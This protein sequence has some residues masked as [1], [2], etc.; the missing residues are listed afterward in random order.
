M[1]V[2]NSFDDSKI[3]SESA[4]GNSTNWSNY[5]KLCFEWHPNRQL[6]TELPVAHSDLFS[7]R[8]MHWQLALEWLFHSGTVHFYFH[9]RAS[10]R[11]N[12]Q[13][14]SGCYLTGTVFYLFRKSKLCFPDIKI[15]SLMNGG[16]LVNNS[17]CGL[18]VY[19]S[20]PFLRNMIFISKKHSLLFSVT[21]LPPL[22]M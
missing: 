17:S 10:C 1:P 2:A 7:N 3:K 5:Y 15:M 18:V 20:Q 14:T 4:T 13:P 19:R 8:Q 21:E 12:R 11:F 16:D 6:A 9:L 22:L